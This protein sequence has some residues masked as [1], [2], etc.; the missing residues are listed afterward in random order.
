MLITVLSFLYSVLAAGVAFSYVPQVLATWRDRGPAS[1]ISL[2]AWS[3][4]TLN[5]GI[6]V[7]YA[8]FVAQDSRIAFAS[9]CAFIGCAT[10]TGIALYKRL[11]HRASA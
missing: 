6:A 2:P 10:T 4:W 8:L 5:S 7:M 11:S 9:G 3:F 1:A